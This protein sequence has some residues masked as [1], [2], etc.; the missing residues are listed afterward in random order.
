MKIGFDFSQTG[1]N[2]AGCGYLA[3]SL[4]R[5]LAEVDAHNEYILYP[6]FGDFFFDPKWPRTVLRPEQRNFRQGPGQAT[7]DEARLFW[8]HP[9]A[10]FEKRLG[11][12]EVIQANNFYCPYGLQKAKLV[13]VLY[14]MGFLQEPEATTETNRIGCFFGVYRASLYADHILAISN[15]S[16]EHFLRVFPYYPADRISVIPLASR[17]QMDSD[18]KRPANVHL[19]PGQFWLNVGTLEPRK[20]QLRLL[21]AYAR[22]KAELGATYPLV[23]AGGKGWLMDDFDRAITDLS[24]EA[25]VIRLGYVDD[26]Q[27]AWLYRHCYAFIYP[28]IFE[29]FGLPVLEAMS[30]GA[31]VIAS[32]TTSLP[33]IVGQA[34]VLVDPYDQEAIFSAMYALAKHPDERE[35]LGRMALQR[36]KEYSWIRTAKQVLEVYKNVL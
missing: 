12:P 13:Y 36:A 9:P 18:T 28:S 26:A 10:D 29:G 16:R 19:Q 8:G 4:I 23:L 32:N 14:D 33:E 27:L 11:E 2:K 25:D 6:T 21:A 3:Y 35:R 7:L 24:L 17:F 31:A 20:N 22:L 15:F 1:D 30:L 34:G 5:A